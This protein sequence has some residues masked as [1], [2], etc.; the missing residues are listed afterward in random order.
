MG[1]AGALDAR[2]ERETIAIV[3]TLPTWCL[4]GVLAAAGLLHGCAGG[5]REFRAVA[6]EIWPEGSE[7]TP[8]ADDPDQE[9]VAGA[10]RRT[11]TGCE[12][13]FI[14]LRR[15]RRAPP[16]AA[17]GRP[18]TEAERLRL[19]PEL[20]A[21]REAPSDLRPLST[22]RRAFDEA[23]GGGDSPE[24]RVRAFVEACRL[25]GIPARFVAGFVTD[26]LGEAPSLARADVWAECY[27]GGHGWVPAD[28]ADPDAALGDLS[29]RRYVRWRGNSLAE[30]PPGPDQVWIVREGTLPPTAQLGPAATL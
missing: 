30:R 2:G 29:A 9:W 18:L 6:R 1:R 27:V 20:G 13:D 23:R 7:P 21:S 28:P 4:A 3:M 10:T 22:A 26:E 8:P 5:A 15:A 24:S 16:P 25:G 11:A 12:Q 17:R 19:T 14:W